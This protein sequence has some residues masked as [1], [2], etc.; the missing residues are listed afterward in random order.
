V[1][2]RVRIRARSSKL[3]SITPIVPAAIQVC[4]VATIAVVGTIAAAT[5]VVA[6]N[7]APLL[8]STSPGSGPR[9]YTYEPVGRVAHSEARSQGIVAKLTLITPQ[10][11]RD[12]VSLPR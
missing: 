7:A 6:S 2:A 11:V 9:R 8:I 4:P 5:T 12:G 3:P 1:A 10:Y